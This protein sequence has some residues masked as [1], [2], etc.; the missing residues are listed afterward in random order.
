M[1]GYLGCGLI[2]LASI[3]V[4]VMHVEP[5][6]AP[7]VAK[8]AFGLGDFVGVMREG[9]VDAAAVNIEV[10][11]E[12]LHGDAGALDVPA[13][14]ANA[15]GRIPL[16]GLIF[17]L[18]LGEPQNEVVLVALVGVLLHALA[19]TDSQILLI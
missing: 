3:R 9:I 15:P 4:Q 17:K 14:I 11:A 1:S 7:L 18:G 8:V 12:V 2:I 16:E 5:V 19:D 10:L 13:G 6:V